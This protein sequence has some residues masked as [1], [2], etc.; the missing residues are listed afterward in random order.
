MNETYGP[1]IKTVEKQFRTEYENIPFNT[2]YTIKVSATTRSKRQGVPVIAS[3]STPRSVPKVG[4]IHWENIHTEDKYMIKSFMP[5]LSERNGP[6][7]GYRIYLVR[8][9][10]SLSLDSK[11][12]PSINELRISTYSEVHAANNTHGGAYIAETISNENFLNEIILGDG[13]NVRDNVAGFRNV[14]NSECHKLLNGYI[15]RRATARTIGI[16]QVTTQ[17]PLL[18][19]KYFFD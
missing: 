1:K 18:D 5:N 4:S 10:Q 2:N 19:G 7:C 17:D 12:L 16:I 11:H 6:I 9:P 15:K 3:C 8:L 13:H 14:R